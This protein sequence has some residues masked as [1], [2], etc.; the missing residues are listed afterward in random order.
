MIRFARYESE[1]RVAEIP[2]RLDER[3]EREVEDRGPLPE[4]FSLFISKKPHLAD[5]KGR[6]SLDRHG[7]RRLAGGRM[8]LVRLPSQPPGLLLGICRN[9]HNERTRSSSAMQTSTGASKEGI[10]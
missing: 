2:L 7:G 10:L 6:L 5:D 1:G 3:S 9:G 4:Q 8:R